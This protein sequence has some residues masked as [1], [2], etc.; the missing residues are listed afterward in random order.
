MGASWSSGNNACTSFFDRCGSPF[1]WPSF[2]SFFPSFFPSYSCTGRS[3]SIK[4]DR[5]DSSSTDSNSK[6]SEPTDCAALTIGG[7]TGIWALEYFDRLEAGRARVAPCLDDFFSEYAS[8][9]ALPDLELFVAE[10]C[11]SK[12]R[13]CSLLCYVLACSDYLSVGTWTTFA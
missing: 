13:L 4:L 5:S 1:S 9:D 7:L 8:Y 2:T 3:S 11:E 10:G 6:L 12:L